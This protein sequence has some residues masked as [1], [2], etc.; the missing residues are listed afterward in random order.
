MM[1]T[2]TFAN[3]ADG[4]LGAIAT[5]QCEVAHAV[6]SAMRRDGWLVRVWHKGCL[7]G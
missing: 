5:P 7:V 3:V 4:L 6:A 1:Y 2:I